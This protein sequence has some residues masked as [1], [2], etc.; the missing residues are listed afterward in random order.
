MP[1]DSE[2]SIVVIATKKKVTRGKKTAS[3]KK[4]GNMKNIG[5]IYCALD[6]TLDLKNENNKRIKVLGSK[7]DQSFSDEDSLVILSLDKAVSANG[8]VLNPVQ[9]SQVLPTQPNV[10]SPKNMRNKQKDTASNKVAARLK[11]VGKMKKSASPTQIIK[12]DG[13][14]ATTAKGAKAD[15]PTMTKITEANESSASASLENDMFLDQQCGVSE[16]SLLS[17]ESNNFSL[18]RNRSSQMKTENSGVSSSAKNGSMTSQNNVGKSNFTAEDPSNCLED[19]FSIDKIS[20]I[21]ANPQ[22][23]VVLPDSETKA[24]SDAKC[25]DIFI[26]VNN[27]VAD[28]IKDVNDNSKYILWLKVGTCNKTFALNGSDSLEIVYRELFGDNME[29]KLYFEEMKLSRFLTVEESGFFPGVNYISMK[30]DESFLETENIDI[31]VKLDENMEN[32]LKV[33]CLGPERVND[34]IGKIVASSGIDLSVKKL[35]SNGVVLP[36]DALIADCFTSGDCVDVIDAKL[37]EK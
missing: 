6:T 11:N 37:L 26:N 4:Q 27:K 1:D 36:G 35:V 14:I 10:K 25:R 33:S 19:I 13:A 22:L 15:I 12:N 9:I 20:A 18:K 21:S 17:S 8:N 31:S 7:T 34:L 28:S 2:D 3:Q 30:D 16:S 29:G 23:S 24:R 5:E 32:D